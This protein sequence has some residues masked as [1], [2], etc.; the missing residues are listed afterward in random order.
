[1][2]LHSTSQ[3]KRNRRI[4]EKYRVYLA[5]LARI[6]VEASEAPGKAATLT[7]EQLGLAPVNAKS[8]RRWIEDP[9]FAAFVKTERERQANEARTE[10]A[11]RGPQ[12]IAWLCKVGIKLR[13]MYDH[14]DDEKDRV[15][16]LKAI[17]GNNAEIRAEERHYEELKTAAARRDF[18][19]F[20]RNL[21]KWVKLN[22]STTYKIVF[23]IL[24]DALKRLDQIMAGIET[25]DE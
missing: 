15:A 7:H 17:H 4:S 25:V 24:R 18:A 23:P 8:F 5:D 9:E 2:A 10:P 1:M 21:V 16:I 20:L 13:E 12:N 22:Y 11:V 19:T 14:P 3:R 6:Y